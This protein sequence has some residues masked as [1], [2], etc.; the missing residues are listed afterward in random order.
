M[1]NPDRKQIMKHT[2]PFLV[3]TAIGI[4]LMACGYFIGSGFGLALAGSIIAA[5]AGSML[6]FRAWLHS[7]VQELQYKNLP[8]HLSRKPLLLNSTASAVIGFACLLPIL[9]MSNIVNVPR[10]LIST[11]YPTLNIGLSPY[12]ISSIALGLFFGLAINTAHNCI[13]KQNI[14]DNIP[15]NIAFVFGIT[16][17]LPTANLLSSSI[18]NALQV[19]S[20]MQ[21]ATQ[22]FT[23][24][25][26]MAILLSMQY[27]VVSLIDAQK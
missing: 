7:D 20:N 8:N 4:T 16:V 12:V 21:A 27:F 17:A 26:I 2:A 6:L 11:Y 3:G 19:E 24:A 13:T 15:R 18:V 9:L 22:I 1:Q 5:T 23:S 10:V 25:A 14:S